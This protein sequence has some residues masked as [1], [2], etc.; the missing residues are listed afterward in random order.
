MWMTADLSVLL[1]V[2]L[3]FWKFEVGERFGL[4]T[5]GVGTVFLHTFT[6]AHVS[7]TQNNFVDKRS[8][9]PLSQTATTLEQGAVKCFK[10]LHKNRELW[11]SS[12]LEPVSLVT[13]EKTDWNGLDT[14]KVNMMLN[15]SS[16][17]RVST[18][19]ATNHDGHNQQ[20]WRPQ[21]CF[22][23]VVW[24]WIRREVGNF[25]QARR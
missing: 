19:M 9:S 7:S 24:P 10:R 17:V 14:L 16:D 25:L 18:M 21:T 6:T 2:P 12:G 15:G 22:L 3:Q 23:Q 5:G 20:P 4:K 13:W 11:E 8:M 1:S